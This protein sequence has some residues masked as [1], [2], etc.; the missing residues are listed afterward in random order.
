VTEQKDGGAAFPIPLDDRPGAYPAEPGM[1]LLDYFAAKALQGI[2]AG[3]E[4][5]FDEE[6]LRRDDYAGYCYLWADSAYDMAEAMLKVKAERQA[7]LISDS[8]Q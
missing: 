3:V 4:N 7:R 5:N 1:S 8:E 2:L 6:V